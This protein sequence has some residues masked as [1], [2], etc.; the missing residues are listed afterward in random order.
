ME[1]GEYQ[2]DRKQ[3]KGVEQNAYSQ[4]QPSPA[5]DWICRQAKL[6]ERVTLVG[7][8]TFGYGQ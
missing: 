4:D 6:Y 1:P 8:G 3:P 7:R 5:D 2:E